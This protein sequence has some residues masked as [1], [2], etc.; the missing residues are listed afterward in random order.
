MSFCSKFSFNL[1]VLSL[2]FAPIAHAKKRP[3]LNFQ[4]Q[5][6]NLQLPTTGELTSLK[7]DGD[8]THVLIQSGRAFTHLA[9]PFPISQSTPMS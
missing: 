7:V 9:K 8:K 6:V 1:I 5:T 4:K 3:Q 2:V